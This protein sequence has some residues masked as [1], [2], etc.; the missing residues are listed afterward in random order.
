MGTCR[1]DASKGTEEQRWDLIRGGHPAPASS[2]A[3]VQLV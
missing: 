2:W 1:E 3:L